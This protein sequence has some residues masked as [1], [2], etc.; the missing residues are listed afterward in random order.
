[1]RM[2]DLIVGRAKNAGLC[3][4]ARVEDGMRIPGCRGLTACAATPI[5]AHFKALG[6]AG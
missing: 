5:L 3:G 2:S 4:Q 1:M 6:P